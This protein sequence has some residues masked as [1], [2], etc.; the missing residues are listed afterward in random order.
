MNLST[1]N[2][3]SLGIRNGRI[4]P[5]KQSFYRN[6]VRNQD[7]VVL[8]KTHREPSMAGQVDKTDAHAPGNTSQEGQPRS[9]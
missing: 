8:T 7:L 9:R 4:A 3:R 5:A 2:C 1:W 6:M